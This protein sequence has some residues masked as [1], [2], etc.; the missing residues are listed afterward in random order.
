MS[1]LIIYNTEGKILRTIVASSDMLIQQKQEDE[2]CLEGFADINLNYINV[3][4]GE[5]LDFPPKPRYYSMWNW[6]TKQWEDNTDIVKNQINLKRLQLLQQSDW[7]ELP[8]ALTRL[9]EAKITEWQTY[10]QALRDIP[11][12]PGYPENVVWPMAPT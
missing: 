1:N 5:I 8:S 10:R 11:T 4:S 6:K 2:L 12:Q 7:T 3:E 9:G